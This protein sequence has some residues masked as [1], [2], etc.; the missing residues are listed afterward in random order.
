MGSLVEPIRKNDSILIEG[1]GLVL[2]SPY[3][4][5]LFNACG[6]LKENKF[7]NEDARIRAI[8]VLHYLI[9]GT[10]THTIP[11]ELVV[12]YMLCNME[13]INNELSLPR[14]NH[15]ERSLADSMLQEI[16]VR[17]SRL[18]NA[19]VK[20]IREN[21]IQRY[22]KL[23]IDKQTLNIEIKKRTYD[24]LLEDLPNESKGSDLPWV[25]REVI[26]NWAHF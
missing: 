23:S 9:Y 19:T 25:S 17:C 4:V 15:K 7:K 10:E 2:L 21:F 1:C 26:L 12:P 3:L 6:F 16:G 14:L 11:E 18:K 13:S 5:S 24:V 22:G 8:A 20:V